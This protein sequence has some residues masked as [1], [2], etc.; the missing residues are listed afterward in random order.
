MARIVATLVLVSLVAQSSRLQAQARPHLSALDSVAAAVQDSMRQITPV[1]LEEV[2]D[3]WKQ[4][5]DINT[6]EVGRAVKQLRAAIKE[7]EAQPT[8]STTFELLEQLA[9]LASA[10][11]GLDTS[12]DAAQDQYRTP[13]RLISRW[14]VQAIYASMEVSRVRHELALTMKELL[15]YAD[16]RLRFCPAPE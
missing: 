14:E 7:S 10:L 4:N 3:F 11:D 9:Y 16:V 6:Y 13:N 1:Q 5:I 2:A 8:L 15:A 12:L